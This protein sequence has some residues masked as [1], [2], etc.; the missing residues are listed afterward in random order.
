MMIRYGYGVDGIAIPVYGLV[1][2][3]DLRSQ[4]R[5]LASRCQDSW[6]Q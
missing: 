4:T 1:L 5:L 3:T 2:F 6:K